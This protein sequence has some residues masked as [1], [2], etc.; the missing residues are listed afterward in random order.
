MTTNHYGAT[1]DGIV[2]AYRAGV[3]V[4][5][6]HTVQYHPTGIVFPEQAEGILITEKFRGSGANLVNVEGNQFTLDTQD[7]P[8]DSQG[9]TARSADQCRRPSPKADPESLC[10]RSGSR[11]VP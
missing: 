1:A 9:P 4:S 10:G 2:L 6:L 11:C 5:F 8:S 7:S 3:P